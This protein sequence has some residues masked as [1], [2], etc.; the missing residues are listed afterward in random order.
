MNT[1][2]LPEQLTE[3]KQGKL[4]V[5]ASYFTGA[6]KSYSMLESAEQ[7]SQAG[8]DVVDRLTLLRAVASNSIVG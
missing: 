2:T 6:G 7:A 4:T 3:K 8:L 1:V 5:F